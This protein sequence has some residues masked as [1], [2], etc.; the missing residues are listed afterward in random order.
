MAT[1]IGVDQV[2][3]WQADRSI[4]KWKVGR[5]DKKWNSVLDAATEQ[6]RRAFKPQLEA[7]AS[8]KEVVAKMCIRDRSK[9]NDRVSAVEWES[10]RTATILELSGEI[11]QP[12]LVKVHGAG[13][14]L[15]AFRCV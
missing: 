10:G 14:D 7:C 4:A 12:V 3:P 2:V 1:Q 11:A 5:T 15:D 8:S 13:E 6:S 9:P